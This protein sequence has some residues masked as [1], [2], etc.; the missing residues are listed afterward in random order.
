MDILFRNKDDELVI[1][2]NANNIV[3]IVK[4][5]HRVNPSIYVFFDR[6]TYFQFSY[7]GSWDDENIDKE[8]LYYLDEGM[9]SYI[10]SAFTQCVK[11]SA[12]QEVLV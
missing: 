4:C 1:H 12:I 9:R 5:H 8:I 7:V 11:E 3:N 6:G 2:E 10:E